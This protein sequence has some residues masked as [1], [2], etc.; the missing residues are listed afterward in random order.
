MGK[1]T[2]EENQSPERFKALAIGLTA[3]LAVILIGLLAFVRREATGKSASEVSSVARSNPYQATAGRSGLAEPDFRSDRS[4]LPGVA[5]SA[6]SD[7][8]TTEDVRQVQAPSSYLLRR[9]NGLESSYQH[10]HDSIALGSAPCSSAYSLALLCAI[11]EL[12]RR[13]EYVELGGAESR[14][15]PSTEEDVVISG[16]RRYRLNRKEFAFVVRLK[17]SMTP[18]E[19]DPVVDP[20]GMLAV[21]AG[22]RLTTEE[23]KLLAEMHSQALASLGS[24]GLTP[25]TTTNT[26]VP[27]K[28]R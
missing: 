8:P 3:V 5:Q 9:L 2:S 19:A 4:T 7:L 22:C 11:I 18:G 1:A 17:D 13:G 6:G 26:I 23:V 15:N 25:S 10:F 20:R 14:E 24:D 21:S 16:D 28:E 12:D 27:R